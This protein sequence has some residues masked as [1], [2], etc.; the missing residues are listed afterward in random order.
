MQQDR[1]FIP[2][3]LI[4]YPMKLLYNALVVY[5]IFMFYLVTSKPKLMFHD[6]GSIKQ[7][8][9]MDG[10]TLFSL[11]MVCFGSAIG[12]YFWLLIHRR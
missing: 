6:D 10:K 8:G 5:A 4:T 3:K 1:N 11:P 9:S 12:I 7:Y 2:N